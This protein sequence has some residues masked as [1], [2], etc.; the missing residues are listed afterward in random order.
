MGVPLA[1]PRP[2]AVCL[3]ICPVR[4][5]P[6]GLLCPR[7]LGGGPWSALASSLP[8]L[9]SLFLLAVSELRPA[10]C[11]PRGGGGCPHQGGTSGWGQ[12]EGKAHVSWPVSHPP[13]VASCNCSYGGVPT[14][15]FYIP[16][17]LG[18]CQMSVHRGGGELGECDAV[19]GR[20][21]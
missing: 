20:G 21:G 15:N 17:I 8:A 2:S 14:L 11:P 6:T 13:V 3:F 18:F 16:R 9:C 5:L 7:R 19:A 4:Y 12:G 10:G 1:P